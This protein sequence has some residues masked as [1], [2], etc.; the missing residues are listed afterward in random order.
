MNLE[1]CRLQRTLPLTKMRKRWTTKNIPKPKC[2]K[3]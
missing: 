3:L 1:K 2:R